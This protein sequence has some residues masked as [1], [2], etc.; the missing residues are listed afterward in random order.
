VRNDRELIARCGRGDQQ[1]FAE[2]FDRHGN[3][4]FRYAFSLSRD[5]DDAQEL[6]Q[7][8]FLTAWKK[9]P[10]IHLVGDSMLPWLI[11][12]C[13][14]HGANLAR[15]KAH[16][17][18][19]ALEGNEPGGGAPDALDRLAHVEE[20]RWVF[21]AIDAL[22]ERDQRIV[23]LCLYEGRSYQEAAVVLG[24]GVG[25][26]TKRIHRTRDRLRKLRIANEGEATS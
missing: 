17:F 15:S 19:F 11:V 1:A 9:L 10:A 7:E 26:I 8:T 23:E 4:I 3:A 18:A 24:L 5:P 20:L 6:V 21:A 12:A 13:R 14:N 16:R 2:L 25:V 22:G